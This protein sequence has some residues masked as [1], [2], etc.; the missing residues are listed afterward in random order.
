MY[1][2]RVSSRKHFVMDHLGSVG[3]GGDSLPWLECTK[4]A[5][6]FYQLQLVGFV[7][8]Y[9]DREERKWDGAAEFSDKDIIRTERYSGVIS[10]G[11]REIQLQNYQRKME[12]KM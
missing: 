10:N 9:E 3:G 7:G 8:A 2:D 4:R 12:Q 11:V 5:C 1:A 6:R